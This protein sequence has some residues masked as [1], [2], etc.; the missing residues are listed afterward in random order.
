[1][2]VYDALNTIYPQ[3]NPQAV[4]NPGQS[5]TKY[6]GKMRKRNLVAFSGVIGGKE[7]R[8]PGTRLSVQ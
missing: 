3:T 4:D 7:R 6:R 5:N 8:M 1:M 2:A